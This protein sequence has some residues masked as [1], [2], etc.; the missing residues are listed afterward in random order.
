MMTALWLKRDFF[1]KT[2]PEVGWFVLADVR[3]AKQDG[4]GGEC[5]RDKRAREEVS[6]G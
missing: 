4:T 1:Q 6:F 3:K 2:L 5:P